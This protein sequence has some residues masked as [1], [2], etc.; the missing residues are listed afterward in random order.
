MVLVLVRSGVFERI[1]RQPVDSNK[2]FVQMPGVTEA[3]LT[4]VQI[5]GIAR[6][7]LLAPDSNRFIRDD[8]SA[9]GENVFDISEDRAETMVNPDGTANDFR[10]EPMAAIP[11]PAALHGTSLSVSSPS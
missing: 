9:F 11:R 7:D 10:R 2:D 3:P 4:P 6:T 5:S 8:D 1:V